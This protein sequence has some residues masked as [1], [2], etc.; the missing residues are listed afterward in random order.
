[1]LPNGI[2]ACV[3]CGTAGGIIRFCKTRKRD[4]FDRFGYADMADLGQWYLVF[5]SHCHGI[6]VRACAI[7][8]VVIGTTRNDGPLTRA[9]VWHRWRKIISSIS[10]RSR[11]PWILSNS[12][13]NVRERGWCTLCDR[14]YS[15][16]PPKDPIST[17]MH[18]LLCPT[19]ETLAEC[20]FRILI[21]HVI[22]MTQFF[23]PLV[24]LLHLRFI[25]IL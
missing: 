10:I 19:S 3:P 4:Y 24:R 25:S 11:Q 7:G 14:F 12:E 22:L 6:I 13:K 15:A 5:C 9:V 17:T 18:A 1:M 2:A 8:V 21:C 16:N 20:Q 23:G